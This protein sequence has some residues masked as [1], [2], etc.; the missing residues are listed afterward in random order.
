MSIQLNCNTKELSTFEPDFISNFNDYKAKGGFCAVIHTD[1]CVIEI[2]ADLEILDDGNTLFFKD[3]MIYPQGEENL[4]GRV[5]KE[6][7]ILTSQ[8]IAAAKKLG[9]K[10]LIVEGDRLESSTSANPG[11]HIRIVKNLVNIKIKERV[12]K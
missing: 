2:L 3:F 12:S 5:R 11:H 8:I 4:K 6:I 10:Q 1:V 9:F 7:F